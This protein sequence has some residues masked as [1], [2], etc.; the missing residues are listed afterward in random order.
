MVIG[1]SPGNRANLRQVS[2]P[3]M[4]PKITISSL[5]FQT[6]DNY[7]SW[8]IHFAS[9]QAAFSWELHVSLHSIYLCFKQIILPGNCSSTLGMVFN[10]V[11]RREV[12]G[13]GVAGFQLIP[14]HTEFA[15]FTE[16][17]INLFFPILSVLILEFW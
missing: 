14:L 17:M 8:S 16:I 6:S 12:E 13:L 4:T 2:C 11:T 10:P 9:L 15:R 1:T 7:S 5:S 3:R